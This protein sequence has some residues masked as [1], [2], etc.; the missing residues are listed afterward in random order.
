MCFCLLVGLFWL[1]LNHLTSQSLSPAAGERGGWW[2]VVGKVL[3]TVF[4]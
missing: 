2:E 4:K 3:F 1:P